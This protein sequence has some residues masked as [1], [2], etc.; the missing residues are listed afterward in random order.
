[1]SVFTT[2]ALSTDTVPMVDLMSTVSPLTVFAECS[3]TTTAAET[4]PVT[5]WSARIRFSLALFSGFSRSASADAGNFENASSVGANTVNGPLSF[6]RVDE[7]CRLQRLRQ[8][9]ERPRRVSTMSLPPGC[10]CA[11]SAEPAT[12]AATNPNAF[13]LNMKSPREVRLKADTT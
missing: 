4:R 6:E 9:R 12:T 7:V 1:M 8:R 2:P 5:T 11:P 13:R 3:L 10:D